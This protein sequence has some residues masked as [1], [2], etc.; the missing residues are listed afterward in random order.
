MSARRWRK[1]STD[2][3]ETVRRCAE[4]SVS[5]MR[6][7]WDARVMAAQAKLVE[8]GVEVFEPDGDLFARKARP[9]WERYM[10]NGRIAS[11]VEEITALE[12]GDA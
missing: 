12:A 3:Q 5:Y 10:K 8:A 11:V 6:V 2:D 4:E 1:L 7:L 9:V